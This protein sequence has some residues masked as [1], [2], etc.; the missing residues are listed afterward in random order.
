MRSSN[1]A[2]ERFI[3]EGAGIP[4]VSCGEPLALAYCDNFNVAGV[5]GERVQS[6]K[7]EDR[8][9]A[10]PRLSEI[11]AGLQRHGLRVHEAVEATPEVARLGYI[12][13]GQQGVVRPKP[14]KLELLMDAFRWLTHRP[15]ITGRVVEK[16]LGH[17][18]HLCLLRRELVG[19]LRGL[20]ILGD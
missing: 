18:V 15:R 9:A 3:H 17:A 13:D 10:V 5:D 19:S 16:L 1:L 20:D 7:H 2:K 11:A 12:V 14:G 8:V 6:V 4:E